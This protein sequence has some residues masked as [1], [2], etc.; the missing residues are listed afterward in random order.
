MGLARSDVAEGDIMFVLADGPTPFILKPTSNG[1]AGGKVR[2]ESLPGQLYKLVS[3]CCIHGNHGW[4]D[5]E[6]SFEN[7]RTRP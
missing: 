1:Y 7:L 6:R 2:A 5:L 4:R 3:E